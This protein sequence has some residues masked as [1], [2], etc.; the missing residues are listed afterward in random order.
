VTASLPSQVV[1]TKALSR[2]K[3]LRRSPPA[4]AIAAKMAIM[5]ERVYGV[6]GFIF[7]F[8]LMRRGIVEM[9]TKLVMDEYHCIRSDPSLLMFKRK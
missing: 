5:I 9:M 4:E 6:F 7:I 3:P 1:V 8:S 2:Y